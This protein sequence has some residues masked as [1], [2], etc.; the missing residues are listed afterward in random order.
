MTTK[1]PHPVDVIVGA[2]IRTYRIV[3]GMSQH[4]LATTLNLTCQQVQ[5]YET[6]ANRISAGRLSDVAHHVNQ[7]ISTFFADALTTLEDAPIQRQTLHLV[8]YFQS[9]TAGQRAAILELIRAI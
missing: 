1:Q 2:N 8:Q 5:K 6:G 9:L 7:P 3:A 4:D